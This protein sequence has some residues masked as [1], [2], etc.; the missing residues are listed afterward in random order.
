MAAAFAI[1]AIAGAVAFGGALAQEKGK[2]VFA[3]EVP[4]SIVNVPNYLAIDRL[5][6]MG[7][8]IE[9]VTFQSPETMSLA[10]QNGEVDISN[11]S[12]GTVFSAIDAGFDGKIFMGQ[13]NTDFQMVAK[14]EFETCESLDG[15]RVAVQSREGTT[16]V[17]T[18]RWFE[19]E[20]PQAQPNILIVPGSENR[21]A[22]LIADQLDASPIDAQNTALLMEQQPGKFHVIDSFAES[23]R[24]LASVFYARSDWL[25]ENEQAVKDF[26]KAYVDVLKEGYANPEILQAELKE[27]VPDAPPVLLDQVLKGW[28]ERRVWNPIGG[29]QPDT[30]QA[31]IEFYASAR[32]YER[33]KTPEDV[34]TT[35]YVEGLSE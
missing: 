3:F 30:M 12:A 2:I 22:G 15:K 9:T 34:S 31:A 1:A 29:V 16:G 26:T 19:Q 27:L 20:C 13:S 17:L 8:E 5:E 32:P 25:A 33:I 28:I 4:L 10:L 21:V 18:A 7:Y 14:T 23:T 35:E 24:L 11:T 6:E